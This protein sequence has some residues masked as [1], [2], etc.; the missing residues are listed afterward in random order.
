MSLERK[1]SDIGLALIKLTTMRRSVQAME[2]AD[3]CA[4]NGTVSFPIQG[5]SHTPSAFAILCT[6]RLCLTSMPTVL[7]PPPKQGSF[8]QPASG[9]HPPRTVACRKCSS[10]GRLKVQHAAPLILLPKRHMISSQFDA[11]AAWKHF[12][13]D[14]SSRLTFRVQNVRVALDP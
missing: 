12:S 6:L 5:C 9:I 13:G 14:A 8:E 2:T 11:A 1:Q 10:T 4:C 7:S 3:C